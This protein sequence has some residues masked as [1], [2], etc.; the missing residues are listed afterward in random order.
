MPSK[1]QSILLGGLVVGLL[2]TSYLGLINM[3][4]CAGV[5]IGAVVAVWHYTDT[6]QL[7]ITAGQGAVMGL[8]AAIVGWLISLVLNFVLIKAGIRSDLVISQFILDRFG[9]N[10]PPE[11]Y[12]QMVDQMNANITI[13]SYLLNAVWGVLFSVVFGAVG[14]AI[15]AVIFK[16]GVDET[17]AV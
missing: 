6:N 5:I 17:S 11:S 10:M 7:T 15:G 13:G 12:D 16:K 8:L 1:Q 9:D 2:S 14:G 4:C 3:L